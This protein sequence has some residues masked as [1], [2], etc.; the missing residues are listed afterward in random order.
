MP[1][2]DVTKLNIAVDRLLSATDNPRHRYLLQAYSRYRFLVVAGRYQEIFASDM[3]SMYPVYHLK[4]AG[5]DATLTGQDAIKSLHRLWAE[6]NQ[7][8]FYVENEE[9]A[10]A[11]HFICSVGVVHQQISGA[12]FK[13]N[14]LRSHLPDVVSRKILEKML[15]AKSHKADE[16]DMYL[17]RS[18]LRLLVPYDDSG[19]LIGQDFYETDLEKAELFKLA[20]SDVLTTEE[21]AKLLA[22]YIKP[23]PSFDELVLGRKSATSTG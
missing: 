9:V 16:S 7:S 13:V 18:A 12:I 21:S 10:V 17:Y 22:P 19:R 2:F 15:A 23:L 8:I 6:T 1:K 20:S 3:I 14:K 5:N 4:A 11:D